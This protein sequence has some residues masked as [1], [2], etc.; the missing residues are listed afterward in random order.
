ME[1]KKFKFNIIDAVII[2]VIVLLA[3]FVV[4]KLA[5]VGIGLGAPQNR[6]C[7]ITFYEEEAADFVI[8]NSHVGDPVYD[9]TGA[10]K[11][12][13]VTDVVTAPSV[14]FETEDHQIVEGSRSGYSAVY[15]TSEVTGSQTDHGLV[16]DGTLYS[17][18]HTLV[19][20]AGQ[21]K[22]YMTVY[23]IEFVD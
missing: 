22:Y 4:S 8:A 9:D 10:T 2:L 16:V 6:K 15:I 3:V 1:K 21:G 7:R 12:G 17:V 19:V 13:T 14:S 11:L 5:G 20:R 18:G 23:S